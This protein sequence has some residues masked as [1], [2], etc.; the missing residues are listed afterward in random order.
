MAEKMEAC[1]EFVTDWTFRRGH[2]MRPCYLPVFCWD[3]R[4]MDSLVCRWGLM[5]QELPGERGLRNSSKP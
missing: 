2:R 1:Y 3:T 5:P 4:G